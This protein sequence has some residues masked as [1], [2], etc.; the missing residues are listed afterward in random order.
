VDQSPSYLFCRPN[1]LFM[2][3][4]TVE[5]KDE[6]QIMNEKEKEHPRQER[7][8]KKRKENVLIG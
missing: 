3:A 5:M 4:K 2:L 6:L 7:N 8:K 1:S